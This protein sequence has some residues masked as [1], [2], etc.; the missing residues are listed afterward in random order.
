[1]TA[2]VSARGIFAVQ[3]TTIKV[4]PGDREYPLFTSLFLLFSSPPLW[5][6]P[7]ESKV[8]QIQR[9]HLLAASPP[10]AAMDHGNLSISRVRRSFVWRSNIKDEEEKEEP[11]QQGVQKTSW[12]GKRG[13]PDGAL[14]FF[15]KLG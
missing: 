5:S 8:I 12:E 15:N 9:D 10:V 13:L 7:Q 14:V 3:L 11:S 1:M 4:G 6:R 2:L